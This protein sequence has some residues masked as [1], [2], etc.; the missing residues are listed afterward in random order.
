MN[1]FNL[2]PSL[3]ALPTL[4]EKLGYIF[5]DWYKDSEYTQRFDFSSQITGDL[6]IYG[7]W[8]L[9]PIE[10]LTFKKDFS[11]SSIETYTNFN[12]TIS[13]SHELEFQIDS[14]NKEI[15]LELYKT[16][17]KIDSKVSLSCVSY[18]TKYIYNATITIFEIEEG[19][20]NYFAVIKLKD[21]ENYIETQTSNILVNVI[22]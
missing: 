5:V 9:K 6:S 4:P 17:S 16:N 8:E 12:F 18:E 10:D 22:I 13:F 21:G 7:K 3:K 2:F 1:Y 11:T 19:E 14:N 20:Y 15:I